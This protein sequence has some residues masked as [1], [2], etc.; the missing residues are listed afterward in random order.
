VSPQPRIVVSKMS[1]RQLNA[2]LW[3]VLLELSNY[4]F[5]SLRS[6][7]V[8]ALANQA[9]ELHLELRRRRQQQRFDAPPL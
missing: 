5:T 4:G 7:E 3:N 8:R 9:I 1:E 6:S 2:R